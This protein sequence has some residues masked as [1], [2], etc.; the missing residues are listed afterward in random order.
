MK[1]ILSIL[2]VAFL[3]GCAGLFKQ[4]IVDHD[5]LVTIPCK[6]VTVTKPVMPLTDNGKETDD[7]FTKVKKALAEIDI[8]KG[9]EA[10]LEAQVNSCK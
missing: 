4:N 10:Q 5:I 2:L 9:Y 8:R 1:L 7:I 3:T 6:T